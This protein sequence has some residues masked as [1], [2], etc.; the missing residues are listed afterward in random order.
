V[1][2]VSDAFQLAGIIRLCHG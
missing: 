2:A 1:A